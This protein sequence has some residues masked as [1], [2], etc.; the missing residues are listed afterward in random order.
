MASERLASMSA[1]H[2]QYEEEHKQYVEAHQTMLRNRGMLKSFEDELCG[3]LMGCSMS[4]TI[5]G[6]SAKLLTAKII[7][8]ENSV[9]GEIEELRKLKNT[10]EGTKR[11]WRA[12]F[13]QVKQMDMTPN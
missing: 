13:Q 11:L 2:S 10:M 7:V 5:P 1:V 12:S 8:L 6:D 4:S 3:A 9:L